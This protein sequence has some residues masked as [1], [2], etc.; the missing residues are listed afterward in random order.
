MHFACVLSK[1][2]LY[3]PTLVT[4]APVCSVWS[5][6]TDFASKLPSQMNALSKARA[7]QTE[8]MNKIGL[9]IRVVIS[10]G[11]HVLIEIPIHSKLWD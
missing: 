2:A 7:A 11:G 9:L 6:V 1:V 8:L 3:Q 5:K 10:Y 4:L